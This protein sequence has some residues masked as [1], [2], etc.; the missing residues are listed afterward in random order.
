M[1][2]RAR[3]RLQAPPA[4]RPLPLHPYHPS[5]TTNGLRELMLSWRGAFLV[6][7]WRPRT[8]SLSQSH[9]HCNWAFTHK[10]LIETWLIANWSVGYATHPSVFQRAKNISLNE[11]RALKERVKRQ[12]RGD[13]SWLNSSYLP[14]GPLYRRC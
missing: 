13:N 7:V 1:G 4:L 11:I 9:R 2:S 5:P 3:T 14:S 8:L 10:P 12:I 6:G